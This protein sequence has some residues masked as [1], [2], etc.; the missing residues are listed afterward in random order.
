MKEVTGADGKPHWSI[1]SWKHVY[2]LKEKAIVK[3]ENLFNGNEVLGKTL[4]VLFH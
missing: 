3:F 2:D 4:L 1:P